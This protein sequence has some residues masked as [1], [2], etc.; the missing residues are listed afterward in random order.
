[1]TIRATA[2]LDLFI[3]RSAAPSAAAHAVRMYPFDPLP[4]ATIRTRLIALVLAIAVPL[5]AFAALLIHANAAHS[6]RVAEFSAIAT[7]RDVAGATEEFLDASVQVLPRLARRTRFTDE[8]RI[9]CDPLLADF[10]A[11][12]PR[13]VNIVVVDSAGELVCSANPFPAGSFVSARDEP[14]FRATMGERRSVLSPPRIGKISGKWISSFTYPIFDTA[15]QARGVMTLAIDLV[16]FEPVMRTLGLTPGGVAGIMDEQGIVIARSAEPQKWIGKNIGLAMHEVIAPGALTGQVQATGLDGVERFHALARIPHTPWIA[17]SGVP[18]APLAAQESRSRNALYAATFLVLTMAGVLA[19]ALGRR[20]SLPMRAM[21]AVAR[22]VAEGKTDCRAPEV[23]PREIQEVA[24]EFNRMIDVRQH[25]ERELRELATRL[26]AL[27]QRLIVVEETERHAINR[28]LHDRI[29]Q[30]LAVLNINLEMVRTQLPADAPA[31][32]TAR[33]ADARAVVERTVAHVRDVMSDLRP[34]ALD[35][36]GLD[37]ALGAFISAYEAR[38]GTLVAYSGAPIEPRLPLVAE[39]AL[40]RI[41]QGA[42][43]NVAKHANADSIE[44]TLTST[45]QRVVL[46]VT[47]DG[48]GFVPDECAASACWG[49]ATMRE[50]AAAIGATL[51]IESAPRAGT[52][53]CVEAPRSP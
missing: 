30:N 25:A 13:I 7:A 18:A 43:V 26:R 3:R 12:L 15:K 22:A 42:L 14:W 27:S 6:R 49:L 29:G 37:A 51:R 19:L 32:V 36:Y 33:L 24:R 21:S 50:R 5:V 38:T 4:G 46:T 52:R 16:R 10:H 39:T 31:E 53:V 45:P 41:A 28:E 48:V 2:F 9:E 44:V 40:F 47:D 11:V 23:G 17:Y 8:G 34:A 35:E 1:V 20:I